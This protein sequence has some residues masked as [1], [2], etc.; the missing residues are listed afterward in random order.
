MSAFHRKVRL[1]QGL[2]AATPGPSPP[3]TPPRFLG[4]HE[5][6]FQGVTRVAREPGGRIVGE[7][8]RIDA[9]VLDESG[10]RVAGWL[11]TNPFAWTAPGA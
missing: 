3:L 10:R 5:F 11:A 4:D 9:F 7:G 8:I 2:L 6:G 1:P